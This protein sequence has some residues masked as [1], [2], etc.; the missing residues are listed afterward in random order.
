[1]A[2]LSLQDVSKIYTRKGR[3][4]N[5]AVKSVSMAIDDGEIIALLGSSGCGKTSTLR[6]IAGFESVSQGSIRIGDKIIDALAPAER[7]V[8]MA[9][10]GYALYPPLTVYDNIAFGL[11][12]GKVAR[13]EVRRRVRHVAELLEIADILER[14]P[15]MLSG[16]QQQRVS[17]ARALVRPAD[18]Y[19]L[20]E[21][22]SQLEPQLRSLLRGRIKDYLIAHRMTSVFVTH[23]QTEAVALADRIAVMSDGVLQQFASPEALKERP[24]NLFVAGFIGEP[25]MNLLPAV[26]AHRA[27]RLEVLL[28][29]RQGHE[30]LRVSFGPAAR[31]AAAAGLQ[32]GQAVQLGVRPHKVRLDTQ[33]PGGD[34]P[35]AGGNAQPAGDNIVQGPLAFNQWQGDQSHIGVELGG[36]TLLVV[37]DGALDLAPHS[38]VTLELPLAALH[39]FDSHTQR[40]VLHGADL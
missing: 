19:L 23:D 30:A 39:L 5:W 34:M 20:D 18:L 15:P 26:V 10:E 12:R 16:G 25:A 1:M 9:F 38:R 40:A 29:G 21:P 36:H 7:N 27:G 33:P 14:Y 28:G 37:T 35:A 4:D 22:M 3:A 11:L 8:A 6:M 31:I 2:S 17:L 24:A 32:D 13:D